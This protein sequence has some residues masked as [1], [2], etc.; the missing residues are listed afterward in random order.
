MKEEIEKIL[1][2]SVEADENGWFNPAEAAIQLQKLF[3]SKQI[4]LLEFAL[5][6]GYLAIGKLETLKSEL[7]QL[8]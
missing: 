3:L 4:E 8:E 1:K 7:K 2:E 6:D 5:L